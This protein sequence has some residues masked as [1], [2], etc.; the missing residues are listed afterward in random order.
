MNGADARDTRKKYLVLACAL[1]RVELALA[2]RKPARSSNPI[3]G[4]FS[5]LVSGP[6][7]QIARTAIVPFLPRKLRAAALIYRLWRARTSA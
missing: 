5:Q 4:G 6:W 7:W 2:W 3:L 1:D